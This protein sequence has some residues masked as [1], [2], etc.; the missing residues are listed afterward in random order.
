[1]CVP[2][3][4]PIFY[5]VTFF[6]SPDFYHENCRDDPLFVKFLGGLT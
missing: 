2:T 3:T 4:N 5:S 1:M 6:L